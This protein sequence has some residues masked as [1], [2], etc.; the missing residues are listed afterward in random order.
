MLDKEE[1]NEAVFYHDYKEKKEDVDRDKK[2]E[3]IK[4][5]NFL[6]LISQEKSLEK[7]RSVIYK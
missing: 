3:D 6:D 4:N 7:V 5:D 2:I 1:V